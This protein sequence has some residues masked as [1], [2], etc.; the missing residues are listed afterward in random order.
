[1]LIPVDDSYVRTIAKEEFGLSY[2]IHKLIIHLYRDCEADAYDP[3]KL[4]SL[5]V[6]L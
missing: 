2:V 5:C 6:Y 4:L 1:M 3:D